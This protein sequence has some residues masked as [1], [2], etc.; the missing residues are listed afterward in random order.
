MALNFPNNPGI[1]SVFT[2]TTAGFSYEWTGSVWKS[3]TPA[4]AS[5]IVVLDDI[6]SSFNNSTTTFDLT[7]DTVSQH[8]QNAQQLDIVLGGISQSP[9]TDYTINGTDGTITFTTAPNS[10]LSFHGVIRGTAVAIDYANSGNVAEKQSYT[11]TAGQTAFTF[12]AGY[13]T[14]YL[15]VFRNG[16]RLISGTDF[17][18]TNTTTFTL[19]EPAQVSDEIAAVGYK[20]ASLVS[21]SGQFQNLNISGIGTIAGVTTANATGVNVTGVI[22]ATTFSGDGGGLTGVASTDLITTSTRVRFLDNL[23]V[24]GVS[25]LGS[26]TTIGESGIHVTGIVTATSFV[27]DGSNITALNGDNIASGTVAAARVATLNQNTTG[28]AGGLSGTPDIAINN[29]TGVAATFTGNVTIGGTIS[30][31][32]VTNVDSLGIITARSGIEVSGIVTARTGFAVT[33]YGDGSNLTGVVS[34]IALSE[35]GAPRGTE[36]TTLN[37]ASGATITNTGAGATIT[38]STGITTTAQ[39]PATHTTVTLNLDSANHHEITLVAGISTFDCAG[40][41]VGDSHSVIINQPSSGIATVG[42][43]TS[44]LFTSGSIPSMS[45]GGGTID[46]LSFVVKKVGTCRTELLTSI[47]TQL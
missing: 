45:E 4:A 34:G 16:I 32:D 37:F 47:W 43:T 13:T 18:E 15:D 11:A 1:G 14:G 46:M 38:I 42:F 33:Y 27:G 39:T 8:P 25:T 5:N 23:S 7:V 19:T 30:Y 26:A 17:T 12:T 40:G 20:V 31:E 10:G 44:F 36:V 28:T 6:S 21:T 22:T 24:S 3:F 29:V 41:T 35:N 9:G 2:D